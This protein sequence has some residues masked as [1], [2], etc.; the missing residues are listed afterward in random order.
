MKKL[1]YFVLL[2]SI[3]FVKNVTINIIR[4]KYLRNIKEIH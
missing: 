3:I 4:I 1:Q 2:N